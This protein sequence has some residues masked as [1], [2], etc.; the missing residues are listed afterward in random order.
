MNQQTEIMDIIPPPQC[1]IGMISLVNGYIA[2]FRNLLCTLE[3]KKGRIVTYT[4][5]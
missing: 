5:T 4:T 1:G 2:K 3:K